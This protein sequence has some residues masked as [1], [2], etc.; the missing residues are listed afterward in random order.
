V[1]LLCQFSVLLC[2]SG[3]IQFYGASLWV[4]KKLENPG[5]GPVFESGKQLENELT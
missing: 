5:N 1:A 3:S 4:R 2:P